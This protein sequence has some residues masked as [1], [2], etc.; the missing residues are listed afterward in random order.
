MIPEA[1]EH[2][3]RE[4]GLFTVMGFLGA[5]ALSLAQ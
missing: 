3:G 5:A 1:H 4:V 2:G